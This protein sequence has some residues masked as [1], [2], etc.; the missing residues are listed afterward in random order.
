MNKIN[1]LEKS[2][3]R[4]S[5]NYKNIDKQTELIYRMDNQELKNLHKLDSYSVLV[6]NK[7]ASRFKFRFKRSY[8]DAYKTDTDML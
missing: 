7:D 2:L 5:Q 3:R 6:K 1:N 4:P 8:S